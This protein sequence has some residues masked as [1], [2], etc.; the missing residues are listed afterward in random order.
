MFFEYP[1]LLWLLAVPLL[2]AALYIY[3]EITDRDPHLRVPVLAQWTSAP[4]TPLVFLRHVPEILRFSALVLLVIA[5]ARPR[6]SS[7]VEKV[8]TEGI[9]I[10][11]AMDVSTSMLAEDLKPNRIEAA[12][13]V[14]SEFI[15]GRP[16]DNIGLSIFAGEAFTQCPMTTDHASLLNML[17][18]VRTDIAARGLI[19][20]GTAI[21]NCF[22]FNSQGDQAKLDAMYVLAT[23]YYNDDTY[24]QMQMDSFQTPSIKGFEE[25]VTDPNMK[26]IT[27]VFFNASNVQLWY[28]QYLPASVTEVH[29]NS[30]SA[31]F[32]L[33]KD[34]KQIGA[35]QDAAMKAAI[36]E[37][38]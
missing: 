21:G 4:K 3:K 19:E 38:E 7:Q 10:V 20:V 36:A 32:G 35:D 26:I 15:A 16:D 27:D 18:N 2:L 12:K 22:N 1:A 23:Q 6:S 34:G 8:D 9:D 28:D 14:A 31:L 13:Q 29:K 37:E 11:F 30:M 24:N 33:E 5:I 17:Q 25:Q